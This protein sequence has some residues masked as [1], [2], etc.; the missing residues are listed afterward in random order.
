LPGARPACMLRI[1]WR[2]RDNG[3]RLTHR[4]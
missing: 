1:E 3:R 4:R 2:T